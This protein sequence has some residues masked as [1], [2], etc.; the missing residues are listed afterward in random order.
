[1]DVLRGVRV[2]ELTM[3]AFMPAAGGVLAH[4]G[5]DVVKVENPEAPDPMRLLGGSLAP[6]D[7]SNTF[8]HYGRGKR[9]IAVDLRSDEGREIVYGLAERADVFLTSYLP[10]TRRRLGVDVEDIRAR[11]PRIIYAKGTGQGPHGPDAERG[12]YDFASWW[13]R[14]SLSHSMMALSGMDE[15]PA[16]MVGHGDGMAGLSLAGGITAALFKRERTGE[17]SVVDG[18]LLGTAIWFNALEIM[19]SRSGAPPPKPPMTATT[20]AYYRTKDDRLIL[21]MH[22]DNADSDWTDL[23]EHLGRPKLACD[24]RFA[25]ATA[26]LE[27]CDEARRELS[28]VFAERTF[29]EWKSILSTARGVWAPH[30]APADLYDDP[31]TLANGFIREVEYARGPVG[32]AAPPI[33]FEGEAGD[34]PRAPDFAQHTDEVLGEIGMSAD[35]IAGLRARGVVA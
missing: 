24:E 25:T 22:L 23:C 26:R 15:P 28:A 10:K 30:Q 35:D 2:V 32:I 27:N 3:W 17:P 29:E 14:G 11:N 7:A 18:S 13:C 1:M 31:Q 6:G 33:L 4:W 5:A 19:A 9:S 34:P 20:A 12:G 16:N 21:V 8:N